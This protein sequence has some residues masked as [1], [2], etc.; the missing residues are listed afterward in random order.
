M[1]SGLLKYT[2]ITFQNKSWTLTGFVF[3]LRLQGIT[4][5]VT[6]N[7]FKH[8]HNRSKNDCS[9]WDAVYDTIQ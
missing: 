8:M 6:G 2:Y 4:A 1:R 5:T 7:L 3:L 9:E